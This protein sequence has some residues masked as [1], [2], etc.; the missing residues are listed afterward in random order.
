MANAQKLF[1]RLLCL[2]LT[3]FVAFNAIFS[4]Y[5]IDPC[6]L[7][8][9]LNTPF[10]FAVPLCWKFL[11]MAFVSATTRRGSKIH[12]GPLPFRHFLLVHHPTST[13]VMGMLVFD[14]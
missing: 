12:N 8:L 6:I 3:Y 13:L 4:P 7:S 9:F 11:G 2:W 14:Y 10:F 5:T 1:M